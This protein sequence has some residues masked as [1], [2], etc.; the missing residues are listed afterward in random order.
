[1]IKKALFVALVLIGFDASAS[2]GLDSQNPSI[3]QLSLAC[4]VAHHANLTNRVKCLK[5]S[6]SLIKEEIN[7]KITMLGERDK[8]HVLNTKALELNLQNNR[9]L[10]LSASQVTILE[11]EIQADLTLLSYLEL[12]YEI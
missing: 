3:H 7:K 11:C 10:G 2:S 6:H 5:N 8:T 12:R 9:C 1:M 4:N